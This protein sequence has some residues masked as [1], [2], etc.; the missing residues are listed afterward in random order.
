M[1][2]ETAFAMMM[3][4]ARGGWCDEDLVRCFVDLYRRGLSSGVEAV[5]GGAPASAPRPMEAPELVAQS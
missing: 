3:D 4:D 5:H 1:P 2:V